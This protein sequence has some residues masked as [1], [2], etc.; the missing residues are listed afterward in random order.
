MPAPSH[1]S[2][3]FIDNRWVASTGPI[4]IPIVNPATEVA[5][6]TVALGTAQDIDQA[7]HAARRAFACF[8]QTSP[9]TRLTML[10]TVLREYLERADDLAQAMTQE[11]GAP[12]AFSKR[13]QVGIGAA[14]LKQMIN[15]L[16]TFEF[17]YSKGST[18][19]V[20]EPI[21]VV[22]LITPWNWPMNQIVC[23]VAPAI[24]AGCTVILKP[25]ELAPLCAQVFAEIIEAAGLPAGVF[26]MVQ[27]DGS[28]GQA[29]AT[30]PG[31][32]MMSFTGSTRAGVAVAKAAADTVKRVAQELGGKSANLV[33]DDAN[34]SKAIPEAVLECFGNTGQSCNAPTRLLVPEARYDEAVTLAKAAAATVVVGDPLNPTTTMG[35]VANRNQFDKIQ[36]LIELGMQEEAEL[37]VGGTGR[38]A[39]LQRGFYVRPT[40]FGRVTPNMTIAREEIFGPVLSIITYGTEDE[41]IHLAN[42]TVYGLAAYVQSGSVERARRV[43]RL[44]RAGTVYINNPPW[45]PSVPFGGY[46]Q[47]GNGREYAEF[48]LHD[49]LEIKGIAGYE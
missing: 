40:I 10:E 32:D 38:P 18:R 49:F 24:A 2:H 48:G 30:H 17:E 39:P 9:A 31:V 34:F 36:R 19:I 46:K 1:C 41:A 21:G 27:G 12:L 4:S 28:A 5:I 43:S 42:D 14:H 25:S 22:G 29:L 45:D 7:V 8:A 26:N 20:L 11:M 47:S 35:P 44:L 13:S 37:L 33:L 3:F 15:T 16:K 23:K 6:G